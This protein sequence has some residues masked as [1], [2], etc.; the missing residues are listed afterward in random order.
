MANYCVLDLE[1]C[2]IPKKKRLQKKYSLEIIQIG[3]VFLNEEL[4]VTNTFKSYI[5]PSYGGELDQHVMDLT[6]IKNHH[7]KSAPSAKEIIEK[8]GAMVDDDTFFV[9]WGD[10][11]T[12]MIERQLDL[13]HLATGNDI[14]VPEYFDELLY[15]YIDCQQLFSEVLDAPLDKLYRLSDAV[16]ISN[17]KSDDHFHDALSDAKNTASLFKKIYEEGENFTVSPYYIR[18]CDAATMWSDPFAQ[19]YYT[20]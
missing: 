16:M 6:G 2:T 13:E 3:C 8:L 14:K 9:T 10:S 1:F 11:D 20:V 7:L 12:K 4:E 15:D 19:R 18:E 17:I 5:K